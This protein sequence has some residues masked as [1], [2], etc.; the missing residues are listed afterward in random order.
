VLEQRTLSISQLICVRLL[1]DLADPNISP[2]RLQQLVGADPGLALRLLRAANSGAS[3]PNTEIT[4]LRQALVLIGPKILRSWVVLTLLEGHTI[5]NSSTAL[6]NV[7]ARAHA[8]ARLAGPATELGFTI[9]LLS[10]AAALLGTEPIEVAEH[11]GVGTEVM[12]AL[13]DRKG[14][15]GTALSAVLA[16]EKEDWQ[17]IAET[18]LEPGEVSRI[19]LQSVSESLKLVHE[20]LES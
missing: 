15:A 12:A 17:A 18:G 10:G 16:Q 20:F 19:Y 1:N 9:G 6:W 4:S 3:A 13:V 14:P 7:L 5:R 11:A 8:V 2:G